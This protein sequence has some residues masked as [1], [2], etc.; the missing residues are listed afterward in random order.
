[1]TFFAMM[2]FVFFVGGL[3][4]NLRHFKA[5]ISY[6]AMALTWGIFFCAR[7]K[8]LDVVLWYVIGVLVGCCINIFLKKKSNISNES[9]Y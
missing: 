6:Y 3:L 9:K 1:M 2:C 7:F 4:I 8:N 5:S